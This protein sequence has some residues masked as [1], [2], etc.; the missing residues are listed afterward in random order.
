MLCLLSQGVAI[1]PRTMECCATMVW[2]SHLALMLWLQSHLSQHGCHSI[3]MWFWHCSI[4]AWV[5]HHGIMAQ[6]WCCSIMVW[7]WFCTVILRHPSYGH[8]SSMRFHWPWAHTYCLPDLVILV[9]TPWTHS[10]L[11]SPWC[12]PSPWPNAS[13]AQ[14]LQWVQRY[15]QKLYTNMFLFVVHSLPPFGCLS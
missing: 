4:M 11:T 9:S 10:S 14:K 1:L 3:M 13:G 5:W 2:F 15:V 6:V 7:V 8:A 12:T